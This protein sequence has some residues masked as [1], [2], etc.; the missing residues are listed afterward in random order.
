MAEKHKNG[1]EPRPSLRVGPRVMGASVDG[2]IF[3]K[4]FLPHLCIFIFICMSWGSF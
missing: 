1:F 2:Q 4:N 3:F